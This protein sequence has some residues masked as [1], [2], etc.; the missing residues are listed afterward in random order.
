MLR[1]VFGPK[2]DELTG[3]WKKDYMAEELYGL[4]CSQNI[5]CL[6]KSRRMRWSGHEVDGRVAYKVL[7]GRRERKRPPEV[8]RH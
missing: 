1:E 3:Q 6:I 5:T 8:P 4:Y 2:R 7:V